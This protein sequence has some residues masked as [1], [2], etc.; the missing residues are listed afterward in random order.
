M[1]DLERDIMDSFFGRSGFGGPPVGGPLGGFGHPFGN[2]DPFDRSQHSE[3]RGGFGGPP[4]GK[5]H[6]SFA[7][8][9]HRNLIDEI[10]RE[11]LGRAMHRPDIHDRFQ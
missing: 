3:F 6:E 2:N 9:L 1:D 10:E 5:R 11:M 4:P 8:N 7:D